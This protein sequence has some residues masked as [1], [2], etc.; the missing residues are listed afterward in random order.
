MP[1]GKMVKV[2]MNLHYNFEDFQYIT[3]SDGFKSKRYKHWCKSCLKDRGYAYKNKIIKEELCHSCKMQQPEVLAKISANSATLVHTPESKAKITNGLYKAH[4]S[5]AINSR[6]GKNL[7]GRLG[8]AVKHSYKTG[9]AVDDLGCTIDEF[10]IHIESQWLEGM[11]WE[12][13]ARFGWHL[14]HIIPLSR[15]NLQD[16]VELKKACHYTNIQPLWWRDNISK[17]STDGST[18]DSGK[19]S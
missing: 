18:R 16:V 19:D 9:S 4:G 12:N 14:D 17:G 13:W 6:I 10:K 3:R 5:N 1:M 2:F 11:T 15:F 8:Q 7:R